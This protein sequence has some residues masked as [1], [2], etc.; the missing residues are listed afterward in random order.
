MENFQFRENGQKGQ[1][2]IIQQIL[3]LIEIEFLKPQEDNI[4]KGEGNGE[5]MNRKGTKRNN[6]RK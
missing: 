1:S 6:S 5:R 2:T 4:R 3:I